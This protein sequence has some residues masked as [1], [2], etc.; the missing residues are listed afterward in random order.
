MVRKKSISS[1]VKTRKEAYK[2]R[3]QIH[4]RVSRSWR[5]LILT[6]KA[7]KRFSSF[8]HNVSAV[9]R[10]PRLLDISEMDLIDSHCISFGNKLKIQDNCS[11][12]TQL[13]E[14]FD[15]LNIVQDIVKKVVSKVCRL[16][17]ERKRQSKNRKAQKETR[18]ILSNEELITK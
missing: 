11:D 4:S 10:V 3:Q 18:K 15:E 17:N 16:D 6:I 7:V 9:S 5:I 8:K 2:R 12:S 13:N 14:Q 1:K